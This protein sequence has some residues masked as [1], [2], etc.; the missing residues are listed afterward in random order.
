M[1][2]MASG[3][4]VLQNSSHTELYSVWG[5]TER[6]WKKKEYREAFFL[7]GA[8]S[9]HLKKTWIELRQEEKKQ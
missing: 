1:P 4:T 7:I 2:A 3:V 6:R 8:F 5:E 9:E